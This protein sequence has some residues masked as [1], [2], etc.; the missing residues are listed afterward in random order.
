[1]SKYTT[2]VRF[3]CETNSGLSE[4]KGFSDVDEVLEGSWDKIFT[5]KCEFFDENYRKVL[6]KKILKHYY[7]REICCE[8]VGLWKLWLNTRLEEVM[9]YFN[10]LY[11]SELLEFNPLYDVNLTRKN[12]GTKNG[13]STETINGGSSNSETITDS[14]T[15]NE[16][17]TDSGTTSN[18]S[19]T[20]TDDTTKTTNSNTQT[21]GRTT[22]DQGT[23]T[24]NIDTNNASQNKVVTDDDKSDLYSDTPQGSLTNIKNNGYLTNA[25]FNTDDSTVTTTG[26]G[27]EHTKDATSVN[28]VVSEDIT[29][30]DTGNGT[31]VRSVES[32]VTGSGTSGNTRTVDGSNDNTRNVTGNSSNNETKDGSSNSTEEYLETVSGKQSTESYSSLLMKYRDTFLNIDMQVIA[33]FDD[34]FF[35]LW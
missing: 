30:K 7:M 23:T 27:E 19:K 5:T 34:L 25:R 6:C 28:D 26:S 33:R 29:T 4:S 31:E 18:T 22:K 2:E 17:I 10:Q 8:T 21:V 32:S 15:N 1:M 12:N 9:P 3:I 20:V 16:T 13:T 35:G 11:K 24:R 14:G